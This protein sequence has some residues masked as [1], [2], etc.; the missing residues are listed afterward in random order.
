M[1]ID[2][3]Y[4]NDVK[5][6]KNKKAFVYNPGDFEFELEF[7]T[8]WTLPHFSFKSQYVKRYLISCIKNIVCELSRG[9]PYN[10]SFSLG[11]DSS[12]VNNNPA[13]FLSPEALKDS[14]NSPRKTKSL[15]NSNILH[16]FN[17]NSLQQHI[18]DLTEPKCHKTK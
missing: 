8:I 6:K 15:D 1:T 4:G 9:L 5:R 13:I 17:N 18:S 16:M 2:I 10:L 11:T 12:K 14:A 3:T 7:W